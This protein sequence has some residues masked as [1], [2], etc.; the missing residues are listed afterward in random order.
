[1][2]VRPT[3]R[4]VLI[5]GTMAAIAVLIVLVI[6]YSRRPRLS[7]AETVFCLLPAQRAQLAGA[8]VSLG[9]AEPTG[10]ATMLAARGHQLTLRE[11]QEAYPSAF[12]RACTALAESAEIPAAGAAVPGVIL[13][14]IIN[15]AAVLVGGLIGWMSSEFRAAAERNR[16]QAEA[17]G[18]AAREFDRSADDYLSAW[19]DRS[20][21]GRPSDDALRAR[22]ADLVAQLGL[23]QATHPRWKGITPL[24][25]RIMHGDLGEGLAE[26]LRNYQRDLAN[27]PAAAGGPDKVDE[28]KQ[29][30]R[31]LGVD[32]SVVT[33]TLLRASAWRRSDP[34]SPLLDSGSVRPGLPGLSG[35][36]GP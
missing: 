2:G 15:L 3:V 23:V 22:R 33:G 30:L 27:G 10:S 29:A 1:M 34:A 21:G 20:T 7:D 24:R 19:Q 5:I 11:W 28:L 26:S 17:L 6:V 9:L 4:F 35:G 13:S 25:E 36:S 8:A 18:T 14:L 32:L 16:A 31:D 12:D